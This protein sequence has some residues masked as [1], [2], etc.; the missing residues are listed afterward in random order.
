MTA[1]SLTLADIFRLIARSKL[2]IKG[3]KK[4]E[5]NLERLIPHIMSLIHNVALPG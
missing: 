1:Y 4:K 2:Y 3:R 5:K